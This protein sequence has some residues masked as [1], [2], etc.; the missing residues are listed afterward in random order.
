MAEKLT[1]LKSVIDKTLRHPMLS[2]L[3]DEAALDYAVDFMRIVGCPDIFTNKVAKLHIEK[4]IAELP[5]DYLQTIQLRHKNGLCFLYASDS[6]HL[7][8]IK[9]ERMLTYKIQNNYIITSIEHG[10]VE[11]S[12]IAFSVDDEGYPMI[13]DNSSFSRALAAYIKKEQFGILFDEQKIPPAVIEKAER[14]YAWAVG[15]CQTEFSRLSLDKMEA[16]SNSISNL[17]QRKTTHDRG[18]SDNIAREYIRR[19]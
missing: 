3:T 13:P 14:D 17:I 6:F 4:H 1:S 7:S 19:H 8:E 16:M 10:D 2:S 11:L 12:Y 15:D 9:D 18:Y 5:C